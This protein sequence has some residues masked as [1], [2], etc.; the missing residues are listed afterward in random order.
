MHAQS[1]LTLCNPLELARLLCPWDFPRKNTRA[2]AVPSTRG[3]Y[4]PRDQTWVCKSSALADRFFTTSSLGRLKKKKKSHQC[5]VKVLVT[6]LCL[7]LCYPM[8][9]SPPV[10]LSMG[11]PR[12]EYWSGLSF[13]SSGDLPNPGIKPGSPTL[14]ADSLLPQ[15]SGK[16]K[17]KK[18]K[19]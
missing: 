3:S 8:H 17:K 18:K 10:P 6:K 5:Q 19:T 2:G 1:C 16:P 13:P 15:P 12:Q 11:F 14:Q 4:W 9:W 7:T